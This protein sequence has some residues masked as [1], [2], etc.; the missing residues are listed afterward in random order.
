MTISFGQQKFRT[1]EDLDL[2]GKSVF[3]RADLN[4]PLDGKRVADDTRIRAILPTLRYLLD[5]G[6][7]VT[8]ASHLGRPKGKPNE[9]YTLLPV[10]ERLAE[11]M[12]REVTLPDDCIGDGV[13]KVLLQQKP[14]Q[15]VLLEN[16]RFHP[17][18]EAN[19]AGFA[20]ELRGS[21]DCFV[22]DAFG[23]LHR[24]HASTH[25]LPKLFEADRRAIG[26]LVAK[27]LTFLS[28]LLESPKR[29]YAV[30][31]GGA[32]ISDKV[33][34]VE[35]L[36]RKVDRIF[37]GGA[38]AFTFLK[39]MGHGVGSSLVESD[40]VDRASRMLED[41]RSRGV[42]IYL[43]KD[44]LCGKSVEEPG[45]P[46]VVEGTG[47]PDGWMGLDIG[48]ATVRHFAD[49]LQDA[50]TIFWNGPLGLFEKP[51]FDQGTLGIA[52]ILADGKMI[53]VIGGGDSASAVE[54]AG[55]AGKMSHISTGGG[56]TLEY[57]EGQPLPGLEAVAV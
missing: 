6:G 51:P 2:G 10:A 57:L 54:K 48:P 31:M 8:L 50:Q 49:G 23:A 33:K 55:V 46:K 45:E 18:E 19:D 4:T 44:F 26:F 1:V 36:I 40:M 14:E 39:A 27:E 30:I 24:A 43:P 12:E 20:R 22:T 35:T 53:R 9:K 47:V 37:L 7:R 52:K 21:F 15:I 38:M 28:P 41:A 13:K 17:E 11:L 16:L 42:R 3:F 56:A 32:K 5:R 29:P 34:V 25:A